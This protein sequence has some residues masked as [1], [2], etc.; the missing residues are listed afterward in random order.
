MGAKTVKL[1][2]FLAE[3]MQDPEVREVYEALEPAYQVASMRIR[4]G[5]TQE[6]LAD[7]VGTKQ[8]SIARLEGGTTE[9]KLF[10]LRR[11]A[12]ALN[13]RLVIRLVPEEEAAEGHPAEDV[14]VRCQ[15]QAEPHLVRDADTPDEG[16]PPSN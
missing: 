2:D 3:Q 16:D 4:R 10:F 6:E 8:P 15:V 9:P 13:A 11:I 12:K 7:L 14:P 1:E 5:L